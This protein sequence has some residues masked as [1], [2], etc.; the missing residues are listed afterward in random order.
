MK[1]KKVSD[2]LTEVSHI[3]RYSDINGEGRLF[4]G[5]LI[6]WID[7]VAS[8]TAKRHAE[9]NVT[10]AAIN[11]VQFKKPVYV[12]QMIVIIGKI[13]YVGNTSMEI[14]IDTYLEEHIKDRSCLINTAYFTIVS[15]DKY[16]VPQTI[17]YGLELVDENE[18]IEWQYALKRREL[19]RKRNIQG[20]DKVEID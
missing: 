14:R 5:K 17:K 3:L 8:I 10:T 7:E 2:S 11:N 16:G 19:R 4:G 6:S 18:K 20:Y 15:V 1:C 9:S 12:N 13:L